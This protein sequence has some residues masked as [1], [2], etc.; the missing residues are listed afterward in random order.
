[1][2]DPEEQL[3]EP[4]I[5]LAKTIE[6]GNSDAAAELLE[7][8]SSADTAL[9]L[10]RLTDDQQE[11]LMNLVEPEQAAGLL[12]Q[13]PDAQ[14]VDIVD[15]LEP[16]KAADIIEALSS[17]AQVDLLGDLEPDEAE[18]ILREM[19]PD[20]AAGARQLLTYDEDSAGGLMRTE[21]LAYPE[22]ATVNDVIEDLRKNAETYSDYDVQ[23]AYIVGPNTKLVGVLRLRDLLLNPAQRMTSDIMLRNPMWVHHDMTREELSRFFDDHKFIGVPVV[24][25][26]ECLIGVV[27]PDDVEEAVAEAAAEDFLKVSGLS[28]KEELRSMPLVVRSRRRLSWLSINIVLNVMAASVIAMFQD[29]L[30]AVIAL[31]VFLPIISDMSGCS[32]SQAVAVSIRELTLGTVRPTE[33]FRVLFKE[34]QVGLINGLALG[35]LLALV[36]QLWKGNPWLGIVVGGALMINTVVAVCLGGMIPLVLKRFQMDPALA[37]GPILTTV[38]DMCGFVLVLGFATLALDHLT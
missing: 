14:V 5:P 21:F 28:G 33:L 26:D 15:G 19:E 18:D 29:T 17:D 20:V 13:M 24:N 31:A 30:S 9:A 25:E 11:S 2:A 10:D 35:V 12:A 7:N 34:L 36:A 6:S 37:S 16:G 3:N 27:Q 23:Y 22:T 4:W 38:T 8:L 1:M 32:G